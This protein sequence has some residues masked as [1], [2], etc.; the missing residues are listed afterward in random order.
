MRIKAA[1]LLLLLAITVSGCDTAPGKPE[2]TNSSPGLSTV[3]GVATKPAA[4]AT[5]YLYRPGED[6][7]GPPFTTIGPLGSDGSYSVDLPAGD[8][9]FLVRQRENGED[10]GPLVEGDLKSDPHTL[11]VTPGQPVTLDLAAYI[12]EGNLKE[13]FGAKMTNDT[14]V[15]GVIHNAEGNPVEGVRVHAYDHVQMSERPKYVSART[16]PDG[17]YDLGL[18]GGGTYYICARDKYGGPPKVGDLYGRYDKG[19]VEPSSVIIKKG[20]KKKD[21]DITVHMVW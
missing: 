4:G 5:I 9:I 6:L 17:R 8:Y 11:K 19:T 20:E 16:G 18:T 15:S 2:G 3:S 12:K 21:V 13:N 10:A 1:P 7:R 14:G